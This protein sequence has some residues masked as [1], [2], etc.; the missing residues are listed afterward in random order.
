MHA[1]FAVVH[2]RTF[3]VPGLGASGPR[4]STLI[5][6]AL[7]VVLLGSALWALPVRRAG[8][9]GGHHQAPPLDLFE[10]A[11]VT[12]FKEGQRGPAFTIAALD[13]SR[14]SPEMWKNKLAIL[15]F[16]ATWC[17]PC[18]DEMASLEAVW[19]AY[20]ARGLVVIG[21]SVDRG[22]PRPLIDPYVKNLGL[23]FRILLDPE[24][25]TAGAWRV[26]GIPTTF[27]IRPGGEVA[28]MAVGPR[29]WNGREMRALVETLL[30][31]A[32]G[33]GTR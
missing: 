16:W 30:P 19:R 2:M 12:A 10:K 29:D 15:N 26:T 9:E 4:R 8:E 24:M 31:D 1:V 20:R 13:G 17:G 7:A 5:R 22:T 28:G 25:K 32:H 18:T 21:A 33:H 11:G 3:G 23:T 27:V 6:I 14:A